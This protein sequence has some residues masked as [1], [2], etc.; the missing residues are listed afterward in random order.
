MLIIISPAKKLQE[1]NKGRA[2][3]TTIEFPDESKYLIEELRKYK[4][5]EIAKLMNVSPKLAE[6]N[7]ERYIKWEYPF[8]ADEAAPA[9][10]M[11]NGDVYRGMQSHN[12]SDEELDFAQKNLRI[13][14]GLYGIIKPFDN[15]MPY[16]LEMGTKLKTNK[17]KNLYEF[18]GE[19]ITERIN[20]N[21]KKEGNRVLINLASNE[22]YKAVKPRKVEGDIITPVFKE[23]KGNDFKNIAI[24]AK[25]ARGLMCRYIIKNSLANVDDL[26]G[27]N[28][29]NYSFNHELSSDKEFVFTR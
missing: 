11:F 25:R 8:K 28:S 13:L 4:P 15:I 1:V 20:E 24:Y 2:D 6:L 16:R 14:S 27:F 23:Q 21:F 12:F 22:Y 18:W 29:E 3:C 5:E 10:F 9:I 17:G 19:K 26:K 7:F